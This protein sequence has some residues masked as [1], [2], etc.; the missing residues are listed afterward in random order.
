MNDLLLAR[1]S[2]LGGGFTAAD[3]LACGYDRQSLSRLVSGGEAV[4]IARGAYA[5]REIFAA[6]SPEQRHRLA[7]R[8]SVA[9]FAGRVAASHYSALSLLG[10]PLWRAALDQVHVARIGAGPGRRSSKLHIHSPYTADVYRLADGL[11]SVSPGLAVLGTAMLCGVEAGVVAAD[12]AL[13]GGLVKDAD[14]RQSLQQLFRHPSIRDARL[15]VDL[16]DMRSES[17]GES[18]TRLV[19]QS[20][21]LGAVVPQVEIRDDNG[22]LVARVDF[23]YEQQRTVVE[24]DGLVKYSGADGREALVAEKRREDRLRDL[25]FQVV[26]VTWAE[27]DRPTLLQHRIQAAFAR[28]TG[29]DRSG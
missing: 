19:L 23:L 17:P 12:A 15:V 22:R 7:T 27:L 2:A 16:A 8:A 9:R 13:A 20:L 1:A 10:L 4:R 25:G 28:T 14:L 29:A 3:A 11:P 26:R 6:A 18:R 21:A 24:F 5:R